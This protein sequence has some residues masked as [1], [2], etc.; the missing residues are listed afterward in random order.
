MSSAK[1][2][3]F[4][5]SPHCNNEQQK[6][7]RFSLAAGPVPLYCVPSSFSIGEDTTAPDLPSLIRLL[8]FL[9]LEYFLSRS[10]EAIELYYKYN[11]QTD[12]HR[13][14]FPPHYSIS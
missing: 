14:L 12:A 11:S 3:K 8:V 9:R 13:H 5:H 7:T 6:Q 2:S 4:S 1:H 10:A